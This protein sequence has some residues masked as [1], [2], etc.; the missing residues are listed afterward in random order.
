MI[1]HQSEQHQQKKAARVE[2]QSMAYMQ[3]ETEY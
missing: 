1:A 3:F 2:R